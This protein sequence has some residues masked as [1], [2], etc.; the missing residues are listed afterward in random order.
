MFLYKS[1]EDLRNLITSNYTEFASFDLIVAV[2]R[3]GLLPA[4]LLAFYLDKPMSTPDLIVEGKL[5]KGGNRMEHREKLASIHSALVVDDSSASGKQMELVKNTLKKATDISFTYLVAYATNESK[6]YV[7]HYLEIVPLPRLF[8]WN[9]LNH[10]FLS[11]ACV[12]IDGVLCRDPTEKEND[13]GDR[14]LDFLS[15]VEP[16]VVPK[17]EIHS[18]VTSRLEKY[19]DITEKWLMKCG[20]RYKN[21]VMSKHLTAIDRRSAGDHGNAKAAYFL[22]SDARLFIE[23]NINQAQEIFKAAK[24]P[25]YCV[26]QRLYLDPYT[27]QDIDKLLFRRKVAQQKEKILGP[28]SRVKHRLLSKFK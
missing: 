22:E 19:R 25:V 12:D 6:K 23:S 3:S 1:V 28:L 15:N 14:Y 5:L 26:D 27:K 17:Y 20:Y 16:L 8:E 11:S 7:D 18:I 13:D 24:K 21:L 4:S 2:P 9:I 10:T